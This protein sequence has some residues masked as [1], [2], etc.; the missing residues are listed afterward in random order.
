MI[1][2]AAFVT[3]ISCGGDSDDGVATDGAVGGAS[4]GETGSFGTLQ[5]STDAV[6]AL[7]PQDVALASVTAEQSPE[8]IEVVQGQ[9]NVPGLIQDP[10]SSEKNDHLTIL[11]ALKSTLEATD[12]EGC[13]AA[14]PSEFNLAQG[15]IGHATCFGP[16]ISGDATIGNGDAGI[17][18]DYAEVEASSGE[19]CSSRV[20]NNLMTNAGSYGRTAIGFVAFVSCLARINAVEL[21]TEVG[22]PVDLSDLLAS[23]ATAD[24]YSFTSA[25]FSYLGDNADG[26]PIFST[27][28][29]GSLT[30]VPRSLTKDYSLSVR[31]V[32][33]DA[34][35]TDYAGV[36]QFRIEEFEDDRDAGISLLY[37]YS[38]EGLRYRY[39]QV[40]LAG[41]TETVFDETSQELDESFFQSGQGWAEILADVD[42]NG[43]GKI[44]FVWKTATLLVFNAETATD[45]TG[46]A[47]FGHRTDQTPVGSDD[48]Y[49]IQGFSCLPVNPGI[50]YSTYVQSQSL[51]L[52]LD[53][54]TWNLSASKT[55]FAPT[56]TCDAASGQSFTGENDGFTK[57]VSGPLTAG[58]DSL[59][60]YQSAWTSPTAPDVDLTV[61]AE[62]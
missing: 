40:Q 11:A 53:T 1:A 16:A 37:E 32:I 55:S 52:G 48:F 31:Q 19:A 45:G 57:T 21:P 18:W 58:L 35:L 49:T 10:P 43:F 59:T 13:A 56:S 61:V 5:I 2:L 62:E 44:A 23:T 14:I 26:L 27:T 41:D 9:L 51:S 20:A 54:G 4:P 8:A 28:I 7:V 3:T 60:T 42:S 12:A 6:E 50:Q 24:D 36:I 22:T 33:A 47:Y 34:D 29:A 17:W 38:A 30:D 39:K 25:S 46:T 15:N